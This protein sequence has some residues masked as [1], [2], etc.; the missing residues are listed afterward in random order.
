MINKLKGTRRIW[1]LIG[2]GILVAGVATALVVLPSVS[3]T[4]GTEGPNIH[5]PSMQ[6]VPPAG[7]H[8]MQLDIDEKR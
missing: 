4:P 7:A 8:R 1:W 6:N 3:S 2:I 5:V